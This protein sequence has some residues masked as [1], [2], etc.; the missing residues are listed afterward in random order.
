MEWIMHIANT[1]IWITKILNFL[2]L[3]W[4]NRSFRSERIHFPIE[5]WRLNND[6]WMCLVFTCQMFSLQ[7]FS[8]RTEFYVE[9]T[10]KFSNIQI[11][12]GLT[13]FECHWYASLV[14]F[15]LVLRCFSILRVFLTQKYIYVRDHLYILPFTKIWLRNFAHPF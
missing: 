12:T 6:I 14:F 9:G 10:Y 8:A 1:L 15:L 3:L 7:P 5:Q 11:S 4:W 2:F 13:L